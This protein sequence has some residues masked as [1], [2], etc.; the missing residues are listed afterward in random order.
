MPGLILRNFR[1]FANAV[2]PFAPSANFFVG[3]NSTGKSSILGLIDILSSH[4]FYFSHRLQSDYVDFS[5]YADAVSARTPNAE[6]TIGYY[7]F[8]YSKTKRGTID[9][10]SIS[11]TENNTRCEVGAVNYI[12]N[13]FLI[14]AKFRRTRVE[15]SVHKAII[16]N[17]TKPLEAAIALVEKNF[18]Q[19]IGETV[20]EGHYSHENLPMPS[21]LLSVLSILQVENIRQSEED[22]KPQIAPYPLAIFNGKW[23]SPIRALPENIST[24]AFSEYSPEGKHTPEIIRRGFGAKANKSLASKLKEKVVSFGENSHLF[25][26][27]VVKEYGDDPKDPYEVQVL[28]G[29]ANQRL[30]NVGYGVSQSLP[31]LTEIA[32]ASQ[33]EQFV[34]QQPEV[35]LHPRAQA[36]F[37]DLMFEMCNERQH[38]FFVETHSDFL[39]DRFRFRMNKS[40]SR[41]K[42]LAQILFF[43]KNKKGDNIAHSIKIAPNGRLSNPI[44][45]TYRSFF[46]REELT[47][48][49]IR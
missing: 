9:A 13:G 20:F 45:D 38:Q 46:L 7:R 22:P 40:T 36:A 5:S 14:S 2:I 32:A 12:A 39:I 15:F 19:M 28:L 26:A 42:P 10:I 18:N 4:Q 37:G 49:G 41:K 30:S 47:I 21:P 25:D 24:T 23:I 6:L 17:D 44:P 35:H 29:G 34:V 27:L 43:E 8:S 11:F 48:L 31:I 3:E 1:G 16:S 33:G